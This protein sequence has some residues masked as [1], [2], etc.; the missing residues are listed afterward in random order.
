M[1]YLCLA[2]G[3]EKDWNVLTKDEQGKLL[4]QD[5]ILR[6]RGALVAAVQGTVTT[7]KAWMETLPSASRGRSM[8]PRL[9]RRSRLRPQSRLS[10][11]RSATVSVPCNVWA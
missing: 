9:V 11:W 5:E 2:Y 6:N 1:K 4:A 7:V 3:D 8:W 10:P